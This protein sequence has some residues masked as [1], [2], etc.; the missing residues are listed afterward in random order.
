MALFLFSSSSRQK[1]ELNTF[2]F[3]VIFHFS[4]KHKFYLL[5]F[6]SQLWHKKCFS[7]IVMVAISEK[8][9]YNNFTSL[10][11]DSYTRGQTIINMVFSVEENYRFEDYADYLLG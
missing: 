9:N 3:H 4:V 11:L 1:R 5:V 6:A 2:K 8:V 10:V 7:Q